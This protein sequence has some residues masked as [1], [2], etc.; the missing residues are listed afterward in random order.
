MSRAKCREVSQGVEAAPDLAAITVLLRQVTRHLHE[1]RHQ[2]LTL[3][4]GFDARILEQRFRKDDS[5]ESFLMN[6][7]VGSRDHPK[8][9]HHI[10]D[11]RIVGQ[12]ASMRQA[13]WQS[14][15]KKRGLR[16]ISNLVRS[17]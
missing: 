4:F 16:C 1:L 11:N 8:C 6:R 14:R 13:T 17:I 7:I 5:Q 9:V 10:T 12:R 15:G 2:R 3:L